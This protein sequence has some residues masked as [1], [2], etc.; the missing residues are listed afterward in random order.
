[1][2]RSVS[3]PQALALVLIGVVAGAVLDAVILPSARMVWA[4][5]Q[6]PIQVLTARQRDPEQFRK[7]SA[8]QALTSKQFESVR[9]SIP[10]EVRRV[11]AFRHCAISFE[12][13]DTSFR[14]AKLFDVTAWDRM[15]QGTV[16]SRAMAYS[17]TG[18]S[19]G[20]TATVV[21]PNVYCRDIVVA[22][23]GR[24]VVFPQLHHWAQ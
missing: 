24:S 13:R 9:P 11:Q 23:M 15:A 10:A 4:Q 12:F 16:V 3:V 1:M 22:S 2:F 21:L 6:A 14:A 20:D 17:E 7:D 19:R 5:R 18:F 8:A